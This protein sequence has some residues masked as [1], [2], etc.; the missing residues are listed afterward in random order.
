[1]N[2]CVMYSVDIWY[3]WVS[4]VTAFFLYSK[5]VY[6]MEYHVSSI[7]HRGDSLKL[8]SYPSQPFFHSLPFI[9]IIINYQV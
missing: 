6:I 5:L 2:A 8:K 3:Q 1:M 9:S 7:L 4:M